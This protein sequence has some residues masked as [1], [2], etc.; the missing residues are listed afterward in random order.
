MDLWYLTRMWLVPC[1]CFAR[2]EKLYAVSAAVYCERVLLLL[3]YD[4][5]TQFL[6]VTVRSG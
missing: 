6:A 3:F 1:T 4:S 5:S 2:G